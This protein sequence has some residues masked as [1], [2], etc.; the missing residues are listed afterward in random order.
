MT[1]AF[2]EIVAVARAELREFA[3]AKTDD[4]AQAHPHFAHV[5]DLMGKI[6]SS[7]CREGSPIDLETAYQRAVRRAGL[8]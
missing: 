7:A 8:E 5:R 3:E 2:H 4:G 6:C 1:P